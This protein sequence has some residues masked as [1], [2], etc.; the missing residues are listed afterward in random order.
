MPSDGHGVVASPGGGATAVDDTAWPSERTMA[1]VSSAGHGVE[2]SSG[3]DT[4]VVT[5][6]EAWA[7]ETRAEFSSAEHGVVAFPGGGAA[8][9]NDAEAWDS[10]AT[11]TEVNVLGASGAGPAGEIKPPVCCASGVEEVSEEV[12]DSGASEGIEVACDVKAEDS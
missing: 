1:D 8:V 10:E 5:D 12:T 2:A 3:S 9:V 6:K 11:M 4:T 7:P